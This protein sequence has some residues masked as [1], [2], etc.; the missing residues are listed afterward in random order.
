MRARRG[1]LKTAKNRPA[2][3]L[4]AFPNNGGIVTMLKRFG[5]CSLKIEIG[6]NGRWR[7]AAKFAG[8]KQLQR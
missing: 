1:P 5:A 4:L 7:P 3:I 2:K 6:V 8:E